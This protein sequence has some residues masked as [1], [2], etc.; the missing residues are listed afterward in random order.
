MLSQDDATVLFS[1]AA[2]LQTP[3]Q[4]AK[5]GEVLYVNTTALAASALQVRAKLANDEGR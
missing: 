4:N 1:S 2:T 5:L 3:W